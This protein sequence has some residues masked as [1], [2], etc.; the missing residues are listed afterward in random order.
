[1]KPYRKT[2]ATI[3]LLIGTTTAALAYMGAQE[4]NPATNVNHGN[5]VRFEPLGVD[6]SLV[7][8]KVLQGSDGTV[9][10]ALTLTGADM[11][12][13]G[14]QSKQP[15]D[16]V[17]VLDR[18]GS[19]QGRKME[20]ARSAVMQLISSMDPD[21]RMGIITYSNHVEMLSGLVALDPNNRDQLAARVDRIVPSG[22]TNLGAGLQ[23]GISM[24]SGAGR[25]ER[26]RKVILVSD[27]LANQGITSTRALGAMAGRATE[28]SLG[29]TTVGVGYDF[30]ELLMTTIADHG[31]GNYYFLE[32]PGA[33]AALLEKEFEATRS[34]IAGNVELSIPLPHGVQLID[35][36]G[37]PMHRKG[38]T[39]VIRPGRRCPW[40]GSS[41]RS[42]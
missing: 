5:R 1:M 40:Q 26:Q 8:D 14:D 19:M 9:S 4:N 24:L 23:C 30:N 7:Q 32:N 20:H 33:F 37:Y 2:F 28:F 11:E 21:D 10:V 25:D 31:G 35:A 27:G 3:L 6:T 15:V 29:V 42:F 13:T 38:N 22:G 36:G 16:L 34:V 17:V 18:S 39:A 41:A 12:Q